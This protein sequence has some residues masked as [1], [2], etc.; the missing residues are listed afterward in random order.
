MLNSENNIISIKISEDKIDLNFD[1]LQKL[2]TITL[3]HDYSSENIPI[4]LQVSPGA[5]HSLAQNMIQ[6]DGINQIT[7]TAED[8]SV[9]TYRILII[10][11]K[12][13][14]N[15]ILSFNVNIEN[16]IYE[17]KID[18]TTNS[19]EIDIPT[20]LDISLISTEITISPKATITP[21]AGDTING[22][23]EI[24]YIVK[25]ESGIERAYNIILNEN[26]SEENSII[27]LKFP[28]NDTSFIEGEINQNT[29]EITINVPFIFD[30]ENV[31]PLVEIS[32]RAEISFTPGTI[33]NFT[34]PVSFVVTA[35]NGEERTYNVN[36]IREE[37]TENYI[38]SFAIKLF[39]NELIQATSINSL[40]NIIHIEV[41]FDSNLSELVP[42]VEI[43]ENA[44]LSPNS[45]Q[46]Q[47]FEN[48][49]KYTVT[50]Q[51]NNSRIYTVIVSLEKSNENFITSFN[52]PIDDE[53]L[54][55]E[56]NN[57]ENTITIDVPFGFDLSSL[58]PSVS[59]SNLAELS[60][61]SESVQN[62]ENDIKYTVTAEN[63]EERIYE[64]LFIKGPNSEGKL[65]EYKV[66]Y[67]NETFYGNIDHDQN[68]ISLLVP[69]SFNYEKA[70]VF[71]N[72]SDNATVI[73]S[74]DSLY[75]YKY[76]VISETGSR[77]IYSLEFERDKNNENFFI[78]FNLNLDGEFI[79]GIIDNENNTITLEIPLETESTI[80]TPIIEVSENATLFPSNESDIDL[81]STTYIITSESGEPRFYD[82][83]IKRVKSDNNLIS[84]FSLS[85]ENQI[86][87]G[88]IDNEK[89]EI[90]FR[91]PE[92]K[93]I[94]NLIP[95][96]EFHRNATLFP[97]E[98]ESQNFEANVIYS[99]V[100]E[101]N[102]L[103]NYTVIVD[104]FNLN[105]LNESY[106]L[107]CDSYTNFS[108]WFGG[109]SRPD[110]YPRNIGAG[111]AITLENDLS[112]ST[113]SIYLTNQFAYD[114]NAGL[115]YPNTVAVKLD[116]RNSNGS[117]LAS[118]NINIPNSFTGGWVDFNLSNL[119]LFLQKNVLYIFT[120]YLPNGEEIRANT[121]IRGGTKITDTGICYL[122]SYS[123]GSSKDDPRDLEDWDSW[124]V[125]KPYQG[126]PD[127]FFNFRLI[128]KK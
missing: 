100:A 103:K 60:P 39:E 17:G 28:I 104:E 52:I 20:M 113:F 70:S 85:I 83:V 15:L 57:E 64:I 68:I 26:K 87:Y 48:Q 1:E 36:V 2:I 3:P 81:S 47:N 32:D 27:S 118:K 92:G 4:N 42:I 71:F 123:A 63:G 96:L 50:S 9:N 69:F 99:V 121:G 30:L 116:I 10:K 7:I 91:I 31:V 114:F 94:N 51:S 98:T 109:D 111:Q 44:T 62:F 18:Q 76:L 84:S 74:G 24:K 22:E 101:N 86:Y 45:N 54:E 97:A 102:D 117:I 40:E 55:G 93:N 37:N 61:E 46:S 38:L 128:G 11:S 8:G 75:N 126:E 58:N 13:D 82:I 112:L 108:Q 35:E 78:S 77:R 16:V 119:N 49:L 59:V 95:I 115:F 29:N 72:F 110:F 127:T 6:I 88:I 125:K 105:D 107:I 41:P 25:S 23:N 90:Y 34:N 73:S 80:T 14:E 33:F 124:Y 19:I 21:N 122:A 67:E 5:I 66:V 53:T 65:I 43:S 56:I 106:S 89:N 120:M 12:N 79:E